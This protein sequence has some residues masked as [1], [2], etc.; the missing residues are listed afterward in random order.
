[1]ATLH[2]RRMAKDY[3]E[4]LALGSIGDLKRYDKQVPAL[5]IDG[6]EAFHRRL[7]PQFLDIG[8]FIYDECLMNETAN[9]TITKISTPLSSTATEHMNGNSRP[10]SARSATAKEEKRAPLPYGSYLNT[11]VGREESDAEEMVESKPLPDPFVLHLHPVE[12][13][14]KNEKQ[15]RVRKQ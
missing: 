11:E 14:V 4:L 12:T 8:K 9:V 15:L 3:L 6:Q 13:A 1:M 7:R 2:V 10:N 5:K